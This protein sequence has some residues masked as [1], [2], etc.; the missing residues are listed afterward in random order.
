M[1]EAVVEPREQAPAPV[2]PDPKLHYAW[3][4]D[5]FTGASD[6]LATLAA[7]GLRTLL[8]VGLPTPAQWAAAGPLDAVGLAG[9]A[10][11]LGPDAQRAEL[12]P[13]AEFLAALQPAITH[14]KCCST[15]DSTSEVGNLALSVLALRQAVH[16][17]VVVVLGGQPSLGRFCAFGNLFA[18]VQAGAEVHRIDRHPTMSHHPVTPMHEADLRRHLAAQGLPD[19]ALIDLRV[20]DDAAAQSG[21]AVSD[22]LCR[23]VRQALRAAPPALLFDTT[24]QE[25]LGAI[26]QWLWQRAGQRPQLVLGASCVAQ[27]ALAHWPGGA[28][29][30]PAAHGHGS[31][32]RRVP[33]SLSPVFLL[34]GSLSPVTAGQ[35]QHARS[36]YEQVDV[37]PAALLGQPAALESLARRC[38]ATLAQGR[39][40][41]ART[42]APGADAP[43]PLEV[44]G[45]CATLLA[46]V[47][48]LSPA[49]RRVGVAGGDTS[50]LALRALGAWGLSWQGQLATGVALTRLHADSPALHGL[51][52][53]LKGGQMGP[54]D[55]FARLLL[56]GG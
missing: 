56:G 53:L 2:P 1:A 16:D 23:A 19:A 38:A 3:Y 45:L 21:P 6:T 47:L 39:P 42:T 48:V 28:V 46:R 54:P 29:P 8:F 7:V 13:V 31:G 26:G 22:T 10:R 37:D 5:D 44:A 49:T 27:A 15:F 51:E 25:H 24:R 43:P 34:V 40:V 17:P 11:A 52:I 14:Y 41:M 55:I 4:G 12:G 50:S 36:L 35:A 30:V 18:T 32:P 20:L 33:A 9:I